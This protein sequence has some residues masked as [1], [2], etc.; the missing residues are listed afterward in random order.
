MKPLSIHDRVG[1]KIE[2]AQTY[3]DDGAFYTAARV[4]R[5]AADILQ[6]HAEFCDPLHSPTPPKDR[7]HERD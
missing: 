2:L 4:L 3:A 7:V 1:D 5:E 6:A